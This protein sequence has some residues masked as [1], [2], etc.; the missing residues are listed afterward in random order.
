LIIAV[1]ALRLLWP[2]KG[3]ND[4]EGKG[5]H[6]TAKHKKVQR[7]DTGTSSVVIPLEMRE[8]SNKMEQKQI[9]LLLGNKKLVLYYAWG[10]EYYENPKNVR[11]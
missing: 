7:Q 9:K 1:K 6:H 2:A 5:S 11:F 10:E 8:C 4:A 3:V